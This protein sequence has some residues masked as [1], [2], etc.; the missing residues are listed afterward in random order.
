MKKILLFIIVSIVTLSAPKPSNNQNINKTVAELQLKIEQLEKKFEDEKTE[1]KKEMDRRVGLTYNIDQI[2]STSKSHYEG[3]LKKIEDLYAKSFES[4]DKNILTFLEFL[5]ILM[6]V[7]GIIFAGVKILDS[8]K[9]KEFKKDMLDDLKEKKKEI[10]DYND[11][12]YGNM[13]I[14][15][16]QN[17]EKMEEKI[18]NFEEIKKKIKNLESDIENKDKLI[19]EKLEN[20]NEEYDEK[21]NFLNK[22]FD[23]KMEKL[24]EK[25]KTLEE[26]FI[27]SMDLEK[28]KIK[29][30]LYEELN[31]EFDQKMKNLEI[32]NIDIETKFI[33]FIDSEKEKIRTELFNDYKKNIVYEVDNIKLKLQEIKIQDFE[34]NEEKEVKLDENSKNDKLI[35]NAKEL[36]KKQE[37]VKI[38]N[39]LEANY[40]KDNYEIN[41]WLGLAN[42]KLKKY[43]EAIYYFEL[44]KEVAST[45][46]DKYNSTYWF[47][48]SYYES[49]NYEK[50]IEIFKLAKEL[51]PTNSNKYYSTY[52]LG[53]SYY[54]SKNYDNAIIYFKEVSDL[55]NPNKYFANYYLAACYYEQN[56]KEKASESI[57]KALKLKP[58]DNLTLKLKEKIEKMSDSLDNKI[59]E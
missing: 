26:N 30:E 57:D 33:N 22:I 31:K 29:K 35:M 19:K 12:N 20:L 47:G 44:S 32:K 58:N 54:K 7:V 15:I 42:N 23:E 59:E 10:Q 25:N 34:S 49:K 11:R 36:Y 37:Y 14:F 6:T 53:M 41:Y 13:M 39:N 1:L 48:I 45:E 18:K 3:S 5:G 56:I 50:A 40:L 46:S 55:E 4:Y 51:A 27:I 17:I 8:Q 52:W 43:A 21:L 24:D 28:E 16:N 38:V 2:Y 9:Y